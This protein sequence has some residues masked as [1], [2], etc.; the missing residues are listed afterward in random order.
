[1]A[2]LRYF[3]SLLCCEHFKHHIE[4]STFLLHVIS[5]LISLSFEEVRGLLLLVR[6]LDKL[7]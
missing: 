4:K 3:D 7:S 1:M 6:H 2:W 5:S